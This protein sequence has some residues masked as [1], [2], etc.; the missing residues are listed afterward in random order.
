MPEYRL[1]LY[2]GA[3]SVTWQQ[4]N[5][6]TGKPETKRAALR[7]KDRAE[8][9]R[10]FKD[11]VKKPDIIN[12]T[13][14]EALESWKTDK[15]DLASSASSINLIDK[16]LIPKFGNLRPDQITVE[17]CRKYIA[18][19]QET[20]SSNWS[21]RREIGL[22]RAALIRV[23]KYTPARFELPPEGLPRDRHLSREEFA[24]LLA[25]TDTPHIR[26]F[27]I[28]ALATGARMS[29]LLELT[30]DRVDFNRGIIK[31]AT[32]QHKIKG[33]A[34]VPMNADARAA[35]EA[36]YKARTCN[37]VIEYGGGPVLT[38]KKGMGRA[39][40]RAGLDDVTAHVLR[41]TAAVWMVQGGID[42]A[43]V[44]KYLGHTNIKVTFKHY[45]HFSPDYLRE[46][47]EAL[48]T[49]PFK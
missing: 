34:T 38:I 43:T 47:A 8:A 9:E 42:L 10:A 18:E 16:W 1:V 19:R 28:L 13:V 3:W 15:Q 39:A 46:A 25:S 17:E 29:A 2:R 12:G 41:H 21:I 45:A 5:P 33:R 44:A 27:I 6:A 31:L 49:K 22:L 36:A 32:G 40:A 26:L 48:E 20:K 23:D 14:G 37:S 35:L 30:W 7:T 11:F 24:K 4:Y